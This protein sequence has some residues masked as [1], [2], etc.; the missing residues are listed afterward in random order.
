MNID[1]QLLADNWQFIVLLG[2]ILFGCGAVSAQVKFLRR[3]LNGTVADFKEHVKETSR[4]RH[5][6]AIMWAE[7]HREE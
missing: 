1:P 7:K 5:R 2:G 6:V 3:D 4:Y